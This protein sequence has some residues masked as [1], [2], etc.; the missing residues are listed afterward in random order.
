MTAFVTQHGE[1]RVRKRMGLPKR[2]VQKLAERALTEGVDHGSFSG[3][4]K[5][6]LDGVFLSKQNADNLRVFHGFLFLFS[7]ET[8]ITC[9]PLPNRFRNAKPAA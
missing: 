5:R 6:Y 8:L 9:W 4:F 3:S 7:C 2:A 1:K